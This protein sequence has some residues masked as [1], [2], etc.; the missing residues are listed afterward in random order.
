MT[1]K[2]KKQ[3]EFGLDSFNI[4][5]FYLDDEISDVDENNVGYSIQFRQEMSRKDSIFS[6][7]LKVNAQEGEDAEEPLAKI[8]TRTS[9]IIQDIDQLIDGDS[10]N[11]PNHLA[12]TLLSISLSTTRGAIAAKT[13]EHLLKNHPLPL[14]NPKQMY[15]DFLRSQEESK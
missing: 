14:I 11:I 2:K 5:S 8:E 15:E 10:V 7:L 6:I 4:L 1:K 13:E 12:V 9:F 3:I